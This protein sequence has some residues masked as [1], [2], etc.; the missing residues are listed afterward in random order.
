MA[1]AELLYMPPHVSHSLFSEDCLDD[2]VG[3]EGGGQLL[4]AKQGD[5]ENGP[6]R[7]LADAH[8]SCLVCKAREGPDPQHTESLRLVTVQV[9]ESPLLSSE[10]QQSIS[11]L[12]RNKR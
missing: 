10:E 5:R 3:E 1:W 4:Q 2:A 7:L 12:R 8:Q 9:Y 11:R 6:P